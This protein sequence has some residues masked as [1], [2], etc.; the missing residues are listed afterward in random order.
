MQR[1]AFKGVNTERRATELLVP[2]SGRTAR[3]ERPTTG[4]K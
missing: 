1:I 3:Q 2:F 4:M